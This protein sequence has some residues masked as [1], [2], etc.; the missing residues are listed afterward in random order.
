MRNGNVSEADIISVVD[1]A[2]DDGDKG[3]VLATA[4]VISLSQKYEGGS[5]TFD[6]STIPLHAKS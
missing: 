6:L 3:T 2:G 4:V 1:E 5:L